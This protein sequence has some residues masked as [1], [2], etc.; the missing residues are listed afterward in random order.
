MFALNIDSDCKRMKGGD[1]IIFC[2]KKY[3]VNI[4]SSDVQY[5]HTKG[6]MPFIYKNLTNLT[7][8]IKSPLFLRE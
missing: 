5:R 4:K 8:K 1:E 7:I 2:D 6:L 3:L